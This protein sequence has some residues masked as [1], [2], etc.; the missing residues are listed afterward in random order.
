MAARRRPDSP[1]QA[2]LDREARAMDATSDESSGPFGW[3]L[4]GKIAA[5]AAAFLA[6]SLLAVGGT[7]WLSWKLEGGAAAVNEAGRLRMLSYRLAWSTSQADQP[8]VRAQAMEFDRTLSA[9]RNGDPS[10]PLF[11]PW[12]PLL[13]ARFSRVSDDWQGLRERWLEPRVSRPSRAEVDR[14]VLE[15]NAF[16]MAVE[17]RLDRWVAALHLLQVSLATLVVLGSVLMMYAGYLLILA[18]VGRLHRGVAALESGDFTARVDI[19]S[20]DELGDLARGFNRMAKHL[21]SLYADL[22]DRVRIKTAHLQAEQK[23]LAALYEISRLVSRAPG[24]DELASGFVR[25]I[26]RLASADGVLLRW[27]DER[28]EHY[29]LLASDGLPDSMIA[30]E[31]CIVAGACHCGLATAETGILVRRIDAADAATTQTWVCAREE[32]AT[33]VRVPGAL[34]HRLLGELDLLY[35]DPVELDAE[36]RSLLEALAGHL[37]S[38]MEGLRSAALE[39]ETVVATER[40]LLARELH[41]S[42]AQSLAFLKIQVQLLRSALR[43]G[44]QSEIDAV[45]G[46]LDAGVRESQ[47]DVRELLL[48]FRTRGSDIDIESALRTTLQKF[49]LQSGVPVRFTL[50]GHGKPPDADVQIQILHVLQEALS[51]ARKHARAGHVVVRTRS[52]PHWSFEI[53]DDGVGFDPRSIPSGTQVGIQI[54]RE[55]AL[56]IGGTL[57]IDS[58]PGSGTTVVLE[59]PMTGDSG[60]RELR[61]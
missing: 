61:A 44:S 19:D 20:R 55:R 7:F 49:E 15:I 31:R 10:R 25:A 60:G 43:S 53:A 22:E 30:Q 14:F 9:L 16:V 42:I 8:L 1:R 24:L 40:T 12:N 56:T 46:E 37:A 52:K 13:R 41:D 58:L 32:D 57:R 36:Q 48:H 39:R 4:T 47:A 59:L 27:T 38:G 34:Q 50:D 21:Q 18:P 33:V 17:R 11:V 35:R 29:A 51:N 28:R 2:T 5:F 6:L 26:R 23:R 54:M 3:T 45:L